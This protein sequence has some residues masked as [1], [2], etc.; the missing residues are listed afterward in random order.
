[1]TGDM[2]IPI[3]GA[4]GVEPSMRPAAVSASVALMPPEPSQSPTSA[5]MGGVRANAQRV[6]GDRAVPES[7]LRKIAGY[8]LIGI[9][10]AVALTALAVAP[11]LGILAYAAL[12]SSIAGLG[13]AAGVAVTG[14]ALTMAVGKAGLA[15]LKSGGA[16]EP[17]IQK[18]DQII[19]GFAKLT[20]IV[21]LLTSGGGDKPSDVEQ[22]ESVGPL[23]QMDL[24]PV[25]KDLPPV[26][27]HEVRRDERI[28]PAERRTRELMAQ[29]GLK[30]GDPRL[31]KLLEADIKAQ[32][33]TIRRLSEGI[34]SLDLQAGLKVLEDQFQRSL[35]VENTFYY[36]ENDNDGRYVQQILKDS[37][38][39]V[40]LDDAKK[41]RDEFV[42]NIKQDVDRVRNFFL[43]N[44]D[45]ISSE[46][47]K[48]A[49]EGKVNESTIDYALP[50]L[51][52]EDFLLRDAADGQYYKTPPRST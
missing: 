17:E 16:S 3:R 39:Q 43:Q 20:L 28:S 14:A 30:E 34:P 13:T 8:V 44:P 19:K 38:V 10:I 18:W 36:I 31:L 7:N 32:E 40:S 45:K 29:Y 26:P 9:S 21:P 6:C 2:G 52:K 48:K 1:M 23:H 15:L 5:A 51:F 49:F 37:E 47:V 27:K 46:G 35:T 11:Y 42:K 50:L 25:S 24:P 41:I 22:P 4:G 33:V 12:G